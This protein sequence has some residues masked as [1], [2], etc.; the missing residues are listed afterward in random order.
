MRNIAL[1]LVVLV[2]VCLVGVPAGHALPICYKW[3]GFVDGLQIDTKDWPNN[4]TWWN[5]DGHSHNSPLSAATRPF[6]PFT[7]HCGTPGTGLFWS[8][9]DPAHPEWPGNWYFVMDF[10]RDGTVD[11]NVGVYPNGE[12]WIGPLAYVIQLGEC[13][14]IEGIPCEF[15]GKGQGRATIQ[16]SEP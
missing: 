15:L 2:G 8:V 6:P 9:A 4:A 7:T 11:M 13:H 16:G 3:M 14:C 5:Y 12:C 10:P 1:A